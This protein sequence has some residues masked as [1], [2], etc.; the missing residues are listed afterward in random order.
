MKI[1]TD[2]VYD[3]FHRGHL[4]SFKVIHQ[5]YPNCKLVVG[6]VSDA[7]CSSYKRKPIINEANRV[8]ILRAIHYIDDIIFPAPLVISQEFIQ[9]HGIDLVV[10]GFS[11]PEDKKKQQSFFAIP[12]Q[13]GIF[14]EIPYWKH[15]STSDIIADIKRS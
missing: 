6:V 5:L 4:E 13:L 12:N 10:H 15:T 1:Y 14:R 11:N 9:Q 3:L 2:G 7:D 8:E